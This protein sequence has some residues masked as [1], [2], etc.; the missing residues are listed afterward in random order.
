MTQSIKVSVKI[1]FFY[2]DE[3]LYYVTNKGI[4]DLPG[5]HILFG[6]TIL[7]ALTRELKEEVGYEIKENPKL[8]HVWEYF[9][10]DKSTHTAY[11]GFCLQLSEKI[12]FKSLEYGDKIKF[13]WL[14]KDDIS[15]QNFL[16][17]MEK[18]L[19]LTLQNSK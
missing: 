1:V 2:N 7:Q 14:K 11:I 4:R 18:I 17:E 12:D 5:G 13:I 15:K 19:L 6:E 8:I 16:P 3:V 9:S 10:K